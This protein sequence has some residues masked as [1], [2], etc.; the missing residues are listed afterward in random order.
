[1]ATNK[2]ETTGETM[3]TTTMVCCWVEGSV[4]IAMVD[5]NA[6]ESLLRIL[7]ENMWWFLSGPR[8]FIAGEKHQRNVSQLPHEAESER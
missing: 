6:Y 3:Q 4:S 1:M 2:L 5:N 7:K 8:K